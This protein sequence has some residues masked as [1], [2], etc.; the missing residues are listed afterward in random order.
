MGLGEEFT[1]DLPGAQCHVA[2]DRACLCIAEDAGAR[3][4]R[5]VIV[6]GVAAEPGI[7]RLPPAV[8]TAA[9]I[10]LGE[11]PGRCYFRHVG[12]RLASSFRPAISRA[13][14]AAHASKRSQSLAAI[15]TTRRSSTSVSAASSAL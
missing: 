2:G 8:E 7:Q 3:N 4:A 14:L 15:V 6:P 12:G 13:G 5:S 1:L 10:F 9:V 11:R